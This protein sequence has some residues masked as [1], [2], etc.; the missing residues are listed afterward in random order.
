[1]R[2]P[3]P[4]PCGVS[5]TVAEAPP[6]ATALTETSGDAQPRPQGV[7][8]SATWD[9]QMGEWRLVQT[10]AEG[11]PHGPYRSWRADGSV[12]TVCTFEHGNENGPVWKF[13]PDGSLFS[14]GCYAAGLARGVHRRYANDDPRA[15]SLQPCCVPAGAWR[16]RE[17]Y[18]VATGMDREWFNRAGQ[19][20]LSSGA[21]HPEPPPGVP[22]GA[23]YSEQAQCWEAGVVWGQKGLNG[24][25]RRWSK[26][27]AL[28]LVE[29]LREG[30]HHGLTQSFGED[31]TVLWEAQYDD[32][33]LSGAYRRAGV[34]SGHFADPRARGQRGWFLNDQVVERWEL[35]DDAGAAIEDRDL[36]VPLDAAA[37]AGSPVLLDAARPPEAWRVLARQMFAERRVGEGLVA[38]ARAAAAAGVAGDL[39]EALSERS[40]RLG[41]EAA[42]REAADAVERSVADPSL[43]AVILIDG[44]KRGGAASPVLWTLAK[45]LPGKDQVA[46]DLIDA[47][48]LLSPEETE[49]LA[50]RVLLHAGRGHVA[51]ARADVARLSAS[52][53][54]QATFLEVLLRSYFPRFAFWPAAETLP[55]VGDDIQLAVSRTPDEVV[56]VIQRYATRLGLLRE[57]LKQRLAEREASQGSE[58][59]MIPDLAG[60]LP[61]GPV[62]LSRWSFEMSAEE[63]EGTD[64]EQPGQGGAESPRDEEQ[65]PAVLQI[66]VD[67]TL[68]V[69]PMPDAIV[70]IL[71]QA[72]A[73]WSGLVWLCW[74]VGLDAPALPERLQPPPTFGRAAV[75]TMERVWRCRDKLRTS[76]LM[77]LT[78]GIAGFEWEGTTIDQL[79]APLADVPL[80][81]YVE[82]R[83]IFS[84]LCDPAN[85]SPWQEDLRVID[86]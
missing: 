7:P 29:N 75:M 37:L 24:T 54:D 44:L 78:K 12:W 80:D 55:A 6:V 20:L 81:E 57:A 53:P 85:R 73:D 17:D 16:V 31:G 28:Q 51:A 71:R 9:A 50:T 84:W 27:G 15:E 43:A 34:L 42:R 19:R 1:M 18:T 3:T 74:A 72:R 23:S 79:P 11:R 38:A 22:A 21:L 67:E 36:G 35:L 52:S 68:G 5:E 13:H 60:L 46:L 2:W 82:A 66:E 40:I 10:D 33:K 58:A 32:G 14:L 48:L 64:G 45:A 70:R 4:Y 41:S 26:T 77:A 69:D 59:F 56:Q 63:Y 25:R 30:Q 76:G 47:A 65:L 49:P 83:A 86:D 8:A 39:V 62:G 61:D